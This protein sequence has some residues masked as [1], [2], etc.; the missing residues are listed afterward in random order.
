MA[1][2]NY[3]FTEIAKDDLDKI[4]NYIA[5]DLCNQIAA[6][7]F[8]KNVKD[9]IDYVCNFPESCPLVE[10]EFLKRRDIRKVVINNYIMYYS[11]SKEQSTIFVLRIIY[12]KRELTDI[13]KQM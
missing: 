5:N 4:L 1:C 7:D 12:G 10:N 6:K 8:Y 9:K 3:S 11:Y 13:L 2:N